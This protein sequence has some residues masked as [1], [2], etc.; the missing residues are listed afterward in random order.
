MSATVSTDLLLRVAQ[1][2]PEQQAAIDR[3]LR[4]DKDPVVSS[5]AAA[6]SALIEQFKAEIRKVLAEALRQDSVKEEPISQ[7]EA[8]RI[9]AVLGKLR[10][11]TGMRK[12]PLHTVFEY[13]VLHGLS[14]RQTAR[15]CNCTPSLISARVKTLQ[16]R[17]GLSVRQLQNYASALADIETTVKGDRR[18][19]RSAGQSDDFHRPEQA[20]DHGTN[21]EEREEE[22][23]GGEEGDVDR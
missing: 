14:G 16:A 17:F 1:A 7:G 2:T 5:P 20:E 15:R 22:P 8:Q 23:F 21:E 3:I 10:T 13:M 9:F 4:K 11:E 12:A 19:R 18:R 6:T